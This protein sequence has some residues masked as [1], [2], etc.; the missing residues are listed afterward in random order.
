[1][2]TSSASRCSDIYHSLNAMLEKEHSFDR[3]VYSKMIAVMNW[4]LGRLQ[5]AVSIENP[6]NFRIAVEMS[7]PHDSKIALYSGGDTQGCNLH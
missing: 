3:F 5:D 6:R 2:S 1:M 7:Q 4:Q